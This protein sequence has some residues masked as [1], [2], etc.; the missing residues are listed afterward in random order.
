MFGIEIDFV[1]IGTLINLSLSA[2]IAIIT[3]SAFLYVLSRNIRNQVTWAF[4]ALL[5]FVTI[6]YAGDLGVSYSTEL[7][8]AEVWLR[9][10][11][12]GIAFVPAAYVHLSHALLEL[13][14]SPSR[15]RRRAF[16]AAL[17][18]LAFV[19]FFLGIGGDSL[20]SS[21]QADPA[22]HLGAG[23]VF[24]VFVIYFAGAVL[25]SL[26]FIV[27]ARQRSL[28]R[29]MRRRMTWLLLSYIAPA[30]AVFPFLVLAYP[31]VL[32]SPLIFYTVLAFVDSVLAVMLVAMAYPLVFLASLLPDRL[33]KAQML[34]YLL[35][36]PLVAIAALAVIIWIPRAGL[37][38][39]LPGDEVMPFLAVGTIL[40]LQWGV[41]IVRPPLERLLIYTGDQAEIRRIHELER[42]LLTGTDF[43][44]LLESILAAL[45]DY[46]RVQTAFVAS[47]G[48]DGPRLEWAIG[49]H[50]ELS[51]QLIHSPELAAVT[52]PS[53]Q[54]GEVPT[55]VPHG[56]RFLWNGF[57]LVPLRY[58]NAE[59]PESPSS[60]VGIMGVA[61][62]AGAT[63]DPDEEV[64]VN[65]LALR[66]A[67][68][69]EDRRLQSEVFA[70]LEGLLPGMEAT[71]R[72]RG[73]ARYGSV[74][75]LTR[76]AEELLHDP[77]FTQFV[78]DA[79][80][81]YWGGPKLSDSQLMG[82]SIVR[83]ALAENEGNPQRALRAVL[84]Q[85][86]ERMKPSSQRSM[87]TA[88][89]ILYNI[90]EMRFIQGRKVR[91]VALR[92]AM[93][94]SDLYRKQRVAIEAVATMMAEMERS[95]QLDENESVETYLLDGPS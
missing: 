24:W 67:E 12:A 76:P 17:Y 73:E 21:V 44:Q 28:T 84:Q 92:L 22:P 60:L 5:L 50:D 59:D 43:K 74:E 42:R 78:K 25:I 1:A 37:V 26:N 11:W 58:E 2:A 53:A 14:G 10:Q 70:A 61:T 19:F 55:L 90:L 34:Q 45:C 86:I 48:E 64:V 66:A 87:T 63:L 8:D 20:V 62:L 57:W 15:G 89:W 93:S 88:E 68:V 7:S 69:L 49:L 13:T 81:H 23:P 56:D 77:N 80:S 72:L 54:N 38:L 30:L 29:P 82:L 51:D 75:A 52:Q 65:T 31:S 32:N 47:L 3:G 85:A 41:S 33:V 95:S 6:T 40:L 35:R 46:L 39:G 91:E 16:A 36:G 18:L 71:Q 4:G 79:L 83:Q 9:F 94:E 27:R